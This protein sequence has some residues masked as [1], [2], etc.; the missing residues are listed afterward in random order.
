[1]CY[2]TQEGLW[3]FSKTSSSEHYPYSP[4]FFQNYY[5]RPFYFLFIYHLPRINIFFPTKK[6]CGNKYFSRFEL[7]IVLPKKK[8][9]WFEFALLKRKKKKEVKE[10]PNSKANRRFQCLVVNGRLQCLVTNGTKN[11][12]TFSP[13]PTFPKKFYLNFHFYLTICENCYE[14]KIFSHGLQFIA[15]DT[16]VGCTIRS[17]NKADYLIHTIWRILDFL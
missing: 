10:D 4:P 16:I 11:R 15:L 6:N 9:Q 5:S 14:I 7:K 8:L 17:N 13:L 1:L 3:N 12:I 2:Q